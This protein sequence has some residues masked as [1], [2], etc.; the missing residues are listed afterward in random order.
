MGS[1]LSQK[2]AS[3]KPGTIH[4]CKSSS[5]RRWAQWHACTRHL[6]AVTSR[7][8]SAIRCRYSA[9]PTVGHPDLMRCHLI[10]ADRRIRL[11]KV[12]LAVAESHEGSGVLTLMC[13]V[14]Q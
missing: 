3:R 2:E 8:E 11:S 13:E 6:R 12:P 4:Y 9:A 14:H 7:C 1:I 10:L 5:G